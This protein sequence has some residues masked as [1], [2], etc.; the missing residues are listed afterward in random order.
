MRKSVRYAAGAVG[1]IAPIL[2]LA[3]APTNTAAAAVTQA[4]KQSAK[5]VSLRHA[6]VT[7]DAGCVGS[8][9]QSVASQGFSYGGFWYTQNGDNTC[10]GTVYDGTGNGASKAESYR[11]RIWAHGSGSD[12]TLAYSNVWRG[13]INTSRGIHDWAVHE[14]YANKI[15]VCLASR[16][17]T[18]SAYSAHCALV[19]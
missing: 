6:A 12:K 1:A 7:P 14:S 5:A 2:G 3:L 8:A 13:V 11:L 4:P 15:L 9:F 10:I 17:N 18:T 16:Y 19:P